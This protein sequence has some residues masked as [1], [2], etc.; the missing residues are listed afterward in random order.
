MT[1]L[2]LIWPDGSIITGANFSE[3]EDALRAS[4]WHDYKTRRAFRQEMRRRAQ[5]WTGR[6]PK[7]IQ[8]QTSKQ[9][10]YHLVNSGMCMLEGD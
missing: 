6:K 5:L 9:F 8:F 1:K 3:L 2:E 7:P 4:Q 10:I